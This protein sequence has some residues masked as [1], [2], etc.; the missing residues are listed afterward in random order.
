MLRVEVIIVG[1]FLV[2]VGSVLCFI[3]HEK[4]QPT[5]GDRLVGFIEQISGETAPVEV[6]TS[7]T[8]GY[9]LLCVGACVLLAG[10]GLI[11]GSR[12]DN[13]DNRRMTAA[14][15]HDAKIN[16]MEENYNEQRD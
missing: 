16:N 4:V 5:A 1:C 12:V 7:K 15:G 14:G 13:R 2:A 11:L 8:Q 3:G 10:L 6:K 9:V